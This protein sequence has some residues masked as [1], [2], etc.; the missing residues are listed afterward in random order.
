MLGTPVGSR[1]LVEETVSKRLDEE[2]KLWEADPWLPCSED[3]R[4][5]HRATVSPHSAHIAAEAI[6]RMA[7]NA[8]WT[9]CWEDFQLVH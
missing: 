9:C 7:R 3:L 2:G 1:Q 6:T 4:A 5:M 8:P